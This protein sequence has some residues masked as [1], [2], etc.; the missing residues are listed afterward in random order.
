[1]SRAWGDLRRPAKV[2]AAA[3][4]TALMLRS[5]AT[6]MPPVMEPG[7]VT[8][9]VPGVLTGEALLHVLDVELARSRRY[10][11]VFVL[12]HIELLPL[13]GDLPLN[14]EHVQQRRALAGAVRSATRWADT[15]GSEHDGSLVVI[16]RETDAAGAAAVVAKIEAE[17][18]M[19]LP[20][21]AV[22]GLRIRQAAWRKGDDLPRLRARMT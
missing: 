9:R 7:P 6:T 1:M 11:S 14:T 16:L 18:A 15:V 21:A 13:S 19:L 17:A 20:A 4:D 3:D 5:E 2:L 22:A 10:E 12:L 8:D